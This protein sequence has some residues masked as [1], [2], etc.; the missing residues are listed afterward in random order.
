MLH[1]GVVC[2]KV[3]NTVKSPSTCSY[4]VCVFIVWCG[5]VF[6]VTLVLVSVFFF[7]FVVLG[8]GSRNVSPLHAVCS[9]LIHGGTVG[10]I[11]EVAHY[12]LPVYVCHMLC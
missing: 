6:L 1:C 10:R 4:L 2:S 5:L 12:K 3:K 7:F 9:Q 11:P 8:R